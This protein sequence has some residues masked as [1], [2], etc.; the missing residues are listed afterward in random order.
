MLSLLKQ[1]EMRLPLCAMAN[2]NTDKLKSALKN[3]G[4]L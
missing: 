3:Y 1:S 4:L 2:A